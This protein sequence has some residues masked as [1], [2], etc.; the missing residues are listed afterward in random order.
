MR[1]VDELAVPTAS[2]VRR[3]FV[4]AMD[5][6]DEGAADAAI[7]GLARTA[8]INDIFELMFR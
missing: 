1:P 2:K 6:W 8:G 7:A 4:E 3:A 5:R